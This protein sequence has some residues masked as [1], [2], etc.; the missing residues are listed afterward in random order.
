MP[1]SRAALVV[2][3]TLVSGILGGAL[4]VMIYFM[5]LGSGGPEKVYAGSHR[6]IEKQI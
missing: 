3:T 5:L 2:S 1:C 4:L 6:R